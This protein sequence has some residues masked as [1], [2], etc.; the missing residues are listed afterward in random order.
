M[1]HLHMACAL[2][3]VH[4]HMEDLTET[5]LRKGTCRLRDLHSRAEAG[6]STPHCAPRWVYLVVARI[7]RVDELLPGV[8]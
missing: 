1:F 4:D 6:C 5:A 8:A 2:A 3:Y 7:I